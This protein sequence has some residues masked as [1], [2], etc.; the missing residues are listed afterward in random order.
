[1]Q[2]PNPIPGC[3]PVLE[4]LSQIDKILIEEQVN[5][6]QSTHKYYRQNPQTY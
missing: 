3:T 5:L 1:M 4:Y 6:L 2:K